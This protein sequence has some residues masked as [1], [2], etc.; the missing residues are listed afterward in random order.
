MRDL[1]DPENIRL[2][3][4]NQSLLHR[5]A[6]SGVLGSSTEQTGSNLESFFTHV[7]RQARTGGLIKVS[8]TDL[9]ASDVLR[10]LSLHLGSIV[11][12]VRLR[13]GSNRWQQYIDYLK[14]WSETS[15][16]LD[17][18]SFNYDLLAEQ[19]LDD[20]GIEYSLGED[21]D[22][23]I[24]DSARRRRLSSKGW[25]VSL[26][27]LHG[28]VAWG[29][30]RGCRRAERGDSV[31]SVFE[32]PYV[33]LRRLPCPYCNDRMLEM[34]IIPP[35]MGK[36]GELRYMTSLW[37]EARECLR[38]ASRVEIIGYSLPS[39]DL[40]AVSLLSE[41]RPA[42]SGTRVTGICG[43]RGVSQS[44][45]TVIPGIADQRA[46]FEGYLDAEFGP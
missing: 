22:I 40:E 5:I 24:Q 44:L 38:S 12:P 39:S 15:D 28:S 30:C 9:E 46:G 19:I 14:S 36:A 41:I 37:G 23:E 34:G 7:W 26:L 35:I 4:G 1:L 21:P 2:S 31:V 20:A 33:P 29:V 16:S 32:T 45:G 13:R 11:G 27:K 17:L 43:G 8:G 3:R 6:T 25:D 10:Q 42:A 18:V